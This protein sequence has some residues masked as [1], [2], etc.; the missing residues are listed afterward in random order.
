[1]G[2]NFD[3]SYAGTSVACSYFYKRRCGNGCLPASV[4]G[5]QSIIFR[6]NRCICGKKYQA[7]MEPS[8]YFPSAVLDR[9]MD[10]L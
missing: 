7:F 6:D 4:F 10:I 9:Y 1:M 2:G 3:S 8:G 5:S